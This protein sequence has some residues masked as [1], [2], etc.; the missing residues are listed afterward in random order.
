MKID[1]PPGKKIYFASDFHLGW[2]DL[3]S[4]HAREKKVLR[5]LDMVRHDA[6]HIFLVGDVFDFWYEY[7]HVVPKGFVRLLGKIAELSDAGIPISIFGGNHDMWMKEYMTE[8]MGVQVF[9]NP[10]EVKTQNHTILLGHGDGLGPGDALYKKVK[11]FF[12]NPFCRMLFSAVHP[13]WGVG[14]AHY[15]SQ[16]RK[17]HAYSDEMMKLR[18]SEKVQPQHEHLFTYC[19]EM[20]KKQH[21]DFYIFG[22]RHKALDFAISRDSRYVNLGDWLFSCTYGVYDGADVQLTD[23]ESPEANI[24]ILR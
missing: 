7:K 3:E 23:Y 18:S 20:E 9:L 14:L 17:N 5:W 12:K 22:H 19:K 16:T 2:P 1:L 8:E 4:S 15:W 21:Y 10:I 13:W 24:Q 11:F 6:A